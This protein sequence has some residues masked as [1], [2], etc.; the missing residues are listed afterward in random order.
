MG[1]AHI[2]LICRT[3]PI[4]ILDL[5]HVDLI[6]RHKMIG[7]LCHKPGRCRCRLWGWTDAS[8][9]NDVGPDCGVETE[10]SIGSESGPGA[11]RELDAFIWGEPG[12][13]IW[14][15]PGTTFR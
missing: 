2:G 12:A 4:L 11:W 6:V 8:I 3:F 5:R 15:E 7:F 10:A 9:G 14:R 1:S 13:D